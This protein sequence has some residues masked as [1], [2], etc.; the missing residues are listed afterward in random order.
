MKNNLCK[1]RKSLNFTLMELL[2]VVAVIAILAGMLLPALQKAKEQ[3]MRARCTSNVKQIGFAI[4]SYSNDFDDHTM[5]AQPKYDNAHTWVQGLIIWG[6]LEKGNFNGEVGNNFRAKAMKPAG[7]FSCPSATGNYAEDVAS[8]NTP[9]TTHYG[10]GFLIGSW[11]YPTPN[12][13]S[14]KKLS[15]YLG[16]YSRVM[17]LGEKKWG[18]NNAYNVTVSAGSS[19]HI[20]D[21]MIRHQGYGNFVFFDGHVEGRRPNM[22]PVHTAGTLYPAVLANAIEQGSS[23]FWGDIGFRDKWPGKL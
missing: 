14:A 1:L 9:T 2:I 13:S 23:A 18:P 7:V 20:L 4:S 19:G 21:G 15:Q 17:M 10:L 3:G 11:S 6:Y 8:Y 5:P 12:A 16:Y 22:I